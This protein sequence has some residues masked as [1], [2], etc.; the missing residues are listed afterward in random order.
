MTGNLVLTDSTDKY[1]YELNN[2]DGLEIGLFTW[3]K[4]NGEIDY[5]KLYRPFDYPILL[6]SLRIE[7][8]DF[9]EDIKDDLTYVLIYTK[10]GVLKNE[11][12]LINDCIQHGTW[13][14]YFKEGNLFWIGNFLYG[15]MHGKSYEYYKSGE[16]WIVSNYQLGKKHGE[17]NY[18]I[19]DGT[20]VNTIH[21]NNGEKIKAN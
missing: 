11:G 3:Y 14:S 18:Y 4:K 1:L 20:L 19:K 2:I 16:I 15:E 8:E 10:K 9:S 12:W 21:Y 7:N 13:K 6:N 17:E 5:C